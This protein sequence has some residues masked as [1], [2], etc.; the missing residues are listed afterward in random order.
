MA[1]LRERS[2]VLGVIGEWVGSWDH[3]APEGKRDLSYVP[4]A[5]SVRR[6]FDYLTIINDYTWKG[7]SSITI[8]QSFMKHFSDRLDRYYATERGSWIAENATGLHYISAYDAGL[9]WWT[10]YVVG[11]LS[12]ESATFYDLKYAGNQALSEQF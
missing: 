6:S 10:I 4:P 1:G 3:H 5:G 7:D 2:A 12:L 11:Y 9:D 8:L